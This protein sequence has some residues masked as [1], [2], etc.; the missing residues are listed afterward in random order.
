MPTTSS[1]RTR[2]RREIDATISPGNDATATAIGFYAQEEFR[3]NQLILR[4]GGRYNIIS[5]DID[6]LQGAPPG[7]DSNSWNKVLFSGGAR[8]NHSDELAV[9]AN[10]G[11]SFKAP[12]S[13]RSAAPSPR[14]QG[15]QHG[16]R[17]RPEP[18]HQ[19]RVR[20]QL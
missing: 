4:T 1:P 2:P 10:L 14:K 19:T 8:Y 18:R 6:L 11:T 7:D 16:Q 20:D 17:P 12:P 3:L 15:R 5:H 13:N 9:Y